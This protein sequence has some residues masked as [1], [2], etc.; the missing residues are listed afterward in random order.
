MPTNYRFAFRLGLCLATAW[1]L[2]ACHAPV[3]ADTGSAAPAAPVTPAASDPTPAQVVLASGESA[4]LGE[5][6]TLKFLRVHND[7]RCPKGAQCVWAGEVTLAFELLSAQGSAPFQLS[8]QTAKSA[9]ATG[10]EFEL[11]D[12]GPCP[13]APKRAAGVECATVGLRSIALR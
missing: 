2:A 6:R 13:A 10:L 7:S 5:G 9:G 11:A 8:S 4:E 1:A 3:L 12:Y